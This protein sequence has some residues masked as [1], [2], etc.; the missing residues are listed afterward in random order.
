MP[1]ILNQNMSFPRQR[2]QMFSQQNTRNTDYNHMADNS[3][4]QNFIMNVNQQN[5]TQRMN[6]EK[7]KNFQIHQLEFQIKRL[8]SKFQEDK[9]DLQH[10]HN[11]EIQR[12]MDRKNH[13]LEKVKKEHRNKVKDNEDLISNLER[14]VNSLAK[15]VAGTQMESDKRLNEITGE[16]QKILEMHQQESDKKFKDLF[17]KS[18]KEKSE[19]QK[20]HTQAFQVLV[21]ETNAR[22]RKVEGEYND[23]QVITDNVVK[24]LEAR[25]ELLKKEMERNLNMIDSLECEKKEMREE[26][27]KLE[28]EFA[29]SKKKAQAN[30][31]K[32]K[33]AHTQDIDNLK[34]KM[35]NKIQ[36]I[37]FECQKTIEK[38]L[39]L[40]NEIEKNKALLEKKNQKMVNL[41][42]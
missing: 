29:E 11:L 18:E 31:S 9:M 12:I 25:T 33:E 21:E 3:D 1:N 8:E 19:L 35:D 13:E 37:R 22:L 40:M 20:Q 16:T 28:K 39:K 24:E 10:Q 34:G 27:E 38:E 2:E 41:L 42:R 30:L 17:Y 4:L 36:E 32:L 23:Q 15:Q 26:Y 14:K 6:L 7:Q 5:E